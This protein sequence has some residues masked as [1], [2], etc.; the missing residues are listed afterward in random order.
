MTFQPSSTP[1][2]TTYFDWPG[3][4]SW[5]R[6]SRLPREYLI[7]CRLI[8]PGDCAE[9]GKG[10]RLMCALFGGRSRETGNPLGPLVGESL[11]TNQLLIEGDQFQFR[12]RFEIRSFKRSLTT[13]ARQTDRLATERASRLGR[14]KSLFRRR[15]RVPRMAPVEQAVHKKNTVRL[16]RMVHLYVIWVILTNNNCQ[17]TELNITS[18]DAIDQGVTFSCSVL[19]QG[20]GSLAEGG[21]LV[22]DIVD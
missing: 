18:I 17:Q 4:S 12:F 7:D 15:A 2:T 13:T 14:R 5:S 21:G 1:R 10:Y 8:S 16:P 11:P 20:R 9:T 19:G 3:R 6:I 22:R